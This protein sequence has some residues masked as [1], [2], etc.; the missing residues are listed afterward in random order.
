MN[1]N[2][3][4]PKIVDDPSVRPI[5]INKVITVQMDAEG[6]IL[7]TLGDTRHVP[8]DAGQVGMAAHIPNAHITTR[9]ALSPT[10]AAEIVNALQQPLQHLRALAAGR[11]V[12][13]SQPPSGPTN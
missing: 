13:P 6:T 3:P 8:A 10:G 12:N 9:L 11:A 4:I 1:P 5:F 2:N 7:L